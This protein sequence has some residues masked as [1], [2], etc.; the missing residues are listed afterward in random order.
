M[1]AL[2]VPSCLIFKSVITSGHFL[3]LE[4]PGNVHRTLLAVTLVEHTCSHPAPKRPGS[5]LHTHS[6]P[7]VITAL[8]HEVNKLVPVCVCVCVCARSSCAT[9]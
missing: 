7:E 1:R 6:P 3:T 9:W 8:H 5:E 2:M 4:T